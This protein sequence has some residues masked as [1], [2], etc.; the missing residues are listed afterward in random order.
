MGKI[1]TKQF[2]V[3][4]DIHMAWDF[5]VEVYDDKGEKGIENAE[6][7]LY[8]TVVHHTGISTSGLGGCGTHRALSEV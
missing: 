5:M 4:T 3:L 6:A 8:G 1:T 2:Q 7:C